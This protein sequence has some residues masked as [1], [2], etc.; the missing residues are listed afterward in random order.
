M[1]LHRSARSFFIVVEE[2]QALG[3]LSVVQ[4]LFREHLA[5][6]G[7]IVALV[8][9]FAD[10]LALVVFTLLAQS[11]AESELL[12]VVEEILLEVGCWGIIGSV[13]KG[14]HV[15]EHA[16]GGTTGRHELHNLVA[17]LLVLVPH[18][19]AFRTLLFRWSL[20]TLT[21]GGG[22]FQLQEREARLELPQLM[23]HLLLR[24]STGSNLL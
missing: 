10:F 1:L 8:H 9:Q 18:F 5:G 4:A 16:A 24:D 12:D 7:L 14:E 2:Q 17:F 11:L 21:Y 13:N 3:Q 23:V 20:Y 15:F 19:D 22:G 6:D